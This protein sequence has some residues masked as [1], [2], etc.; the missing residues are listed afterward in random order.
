MLWQT[1]GA[2]V[3]PFSPAECQ[4]YFDAA[5]YALDTWEGDSV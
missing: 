5:G 4:R 3:G 1:I 2:L